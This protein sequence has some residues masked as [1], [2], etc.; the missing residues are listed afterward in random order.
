MPLLNAQDETV[1]TG[2]IHLITGVYKL[3]ITLAIDTIVWC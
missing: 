1:Q 3:F 2:A